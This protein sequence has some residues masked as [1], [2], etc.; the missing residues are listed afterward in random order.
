MIRQNFALR[1]ILLGVKGAIPKIY[2]NAKENIFH[3]FQFLTRLRSK[4]YSLGFDYE[5]K[6]VE[7]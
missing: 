3:F 2:E 1:V 6:N 7:H 5:N 4:V